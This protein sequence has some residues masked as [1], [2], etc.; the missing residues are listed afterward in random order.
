MIQSIEYE[1]R[2]IS[3]LQENEIQSL[4]TIAPYWGLLFDKHKKILT[5]GLTDQSV[6]VHHSFKQSYLQSLLQHTQLQFNHNRE[7]SD[8]VI[9]VYSI[10]REA[11]SP[12]SIST[13]GTNY[14]L[15]YMK[16][17]DKNLQFLIH[18]GVWLPKRTDHFSVTFCNFSEERQLEI[19]AYLIVQNFLRDDM[20]SILHVPFPIYESLI[21]HVLHPINEHLA[22]VQKNLYNTIWPE[23]P[24]ELIK[25][26]MESNHSPTINH[27]FNPFKQEKAKAPQTPNQHQINPFKD[28][29][30]TTYHPI[31]PFRKRNGKFENE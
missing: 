1:Q 12:I 20:Q 16:N 8:L 10:E 9:D 25:P 2:V 19:L 3:H 5:P 22:S 15:K 27:V 23:T 7:H 6:Y 17:Y 28:Q 13:N 24:P 21:Q 18:R 11:H 14:H 30:K 29:T 26:S 31:N 4:A